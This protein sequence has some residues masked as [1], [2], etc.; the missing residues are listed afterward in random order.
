MFLVG[1]YDTHIHGAFGVD[2]CDGSKDAILTM[3]K[4]LPE[5]GVQ[6]FCPTTMTTT[7]DVIYKAFEAVWDAKKELKSGVNVASI[8]GM[9]LEGPF[10]SPVY[11]GVQNKE[12][13]IDPDKGYDMI[14]TLEKDFPGL[15]K[16]IDIAPE[17]PGAMDFIKEFSPKYSLSLAHTNCDYETA[18]KAFE[19]GANSV[20]H[21]MNAMAP[22]DKRNPGVLGAL[23]DF[24]DVYCEVICDGIHIAPPFLR[25]L[26]KLIRED[27]LIIVSDS[28]RGSGMPDGVYKLAEVDVEVANGRT[29]YGP[30]RGLAGS[31]TNMGEEVMRLQKFG[32]DD[33]LITLASKEN[34]LRRLGTNLL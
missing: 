8:L 16:I 34:P 19:A 21:V 27:R 7:F 2:T 22:C 11:A 31:V 10:L 15:L 1:F 12:C 33:K 14:T 23:V 28:M 29:Y 4:R 25:M 30:N 9:H 26:F 17:M 6:G 3:A 13:C 32:I 20:T 24:P 18:C 5:F